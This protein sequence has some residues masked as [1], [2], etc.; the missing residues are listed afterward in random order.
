MPD[1]GFSVEVVR[2]VPVVAVP[3]EVDINNAAGLRAAL[4]QAA[5]H[6]HETLVVDMTRTQFCDTAGLHAL[7][8][9]HKR[10]QAE[11]GPAAETQDRTNRSTA[12]AKPSSS[13]D[14]V[15]RR[16]ARWTS[17]LALPMAMLSPEWANMSTSFGWSPIVAICSGGIW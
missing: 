1:T 3:E 11:G 14:V 13:L 15:T 6:A 5:T 16:A 12:L 7:L 2:G 17:W 10:A 8:G 9:A 4:L